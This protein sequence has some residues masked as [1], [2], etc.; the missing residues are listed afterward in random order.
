MSV[1]FVRFNLPYSLNT[2][3]WSVNNSCVHSS[4][5]MN[6]HGHSCHSCDYVCFCVAPNSLRCDES[7]SKPS[8]GTERCHVE[9]L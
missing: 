8:F 4:I 5:F 7:R 6:H 9:I 1:E 3:V 2:A